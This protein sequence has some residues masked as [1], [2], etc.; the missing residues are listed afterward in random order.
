MPILSHWKQIK[1]HW[2]L[3]VCLFPPVLYLILFKYIP[4]TGTI[5]AFKDYNVI[6]G[7]WGSSWVGM[8]YFNQFFDSPNFWMYI[9][10][11]LGISVYGLLVGFP[12]PILLALALN[13]IRGGAFKKA[14]QLITYA[15]YFIST[16]VMVSIIIVTLTPNIGVIS[17]LL[18]AFGV[19]NS[20]LMGIPGL[21]KSIYVWSDVWQF[22]GYGAIIYM[23]ALAGVNPELYEAAKVDGASRWQKIRNVDIPGIIPVSVI[24]LVLNCGNV[25]KLGFE[26]VYL[27][28]NALNLSTSEVISTYVY[29]V[30][31]LTASFSFSTAIGL[32]NSVVNVILLLMVNYTARRLSDSSLW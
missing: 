7:I 22:A 17:K 4:I 19:H 12:A 21:F 29:K 20:N 8:K 32:F 9:K 28:Q 2:Q 6:K 23:A 31:L 5:I 27:M 10:N 25:M 16:V 30:G 15:P 3:Y 24:L 1:R 18:E 14:V 26:K 11:T 13:E